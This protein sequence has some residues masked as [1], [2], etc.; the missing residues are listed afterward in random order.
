MDKVTPENLMTF[1]WVGAAIVACAL[2]VWSL[3]ERIKKAVSK[4]RD[5]DQ[6]LK[7]MQQQ[8][9]AQGEILQETC[10]G[11]L[12]LMNHA[13]TGKH[14]HEVEGMGQGGADPGDPDVCADVRRMYCCGCSDERSGVAPCAECE[15]CGIC[16]QHPHGAGR[17][18]RGGQHAI[19]TA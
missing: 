17:P 4:G 1:F 6:Q 8:L 11:V 2:A 18:A 7:D 10:K 19:R 13:I 14:D 3:V 5:R 12:A 15:W 9:T 16:P